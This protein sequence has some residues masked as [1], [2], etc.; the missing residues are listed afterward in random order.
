MTVKP[1]PKETGVTWRCL[2]DAAADG[3]SGGSAIAAGKGWSGGQLAHWSSV[4]VV[5]YVS[6]NV[7]RQAW[8]M[9]SVGTEKPDCWSI[10]GECHE[11]VV[12]A[13]DRPIDV[14]MY[15]LCCRPPPCSATKYK[16]LG[17][18]LH[19]T[20]ILCAIIC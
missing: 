10:T 8:M 12:T 1:R 17:H 15:G 4:N 7:G 13:I 9:G 2:A 14:I 18:V 19:H 16:A 11:M 20:P 3:V 5:G 6:F